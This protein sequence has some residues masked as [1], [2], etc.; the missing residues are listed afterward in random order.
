MPHDE[1]PTLP[2]TYGIRLALS[3]VRGIS[4]A[5]VASIVTALR[6]GP[7][8]SLEDVWRRTDLSRPVLENL[9]HVGALDSIEPSR[10][11]REL[12]WRVADLA[13]TA[14]V[15]RKPVM[16]QGVLEL[17]EPIQETLPGLPAYTPLEETEA[18]LEISGIDARRHV[19]GL[20]GGLLAELGCTPAAGLP[21]CRNDSEV[22]VAGVKVASQTPAIRSG[23]RI[24]FVTLD[25]VTGP[26][27]VTVFERVQPR[28]A[29]TVF[30]SWLLLVRGMVRK[31]GGASLVHTTDP[32]NVGI[33]VVAQEV[34]DLAELTV[35]RRSHSLAASLG[36][37]RRKQTLTGL[38]AAG[39]DAAPGKLWHSSGGS[40]GR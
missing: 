21:R 17:D 40:A 5:E 8:A 33:T 38:T 32:R 10:T 9:V 12:L 14:A 18:E 2:P 4:E 16:T 7:F 37:Q 35:D 1:R 15:E 25:D 11:R 36:R 30:H 28:C 27:D 23:Q 39:A 20:Y 19:M 6:E 13:A 26:I 24:I 22:W 31:R 3:E 29:R 34:F